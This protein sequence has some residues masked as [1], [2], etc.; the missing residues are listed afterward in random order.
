[1]S[2]H[3]G[4]RNGPPRPHLPHS[5]PVGSRPRPHAPRTGGWAW[6]SARPR[7]PHNEARDT[8]P[9]RAPLC[10]PHS[11]QRQHTRASTV[12]LITGHHAHCPCPHSQWVAGPGY[13]PQGQA[14]GRVRAPHP[15]R[16]TP[17]HEVPLS[18]GRPRAASTACKGSSQEH[19][20]S[21][22]WRLPRSGPPHPQ[23]V[24][25][26][27]RLHAPR[28]GSRARESAQTRTNH[29]KA[30]GAPPPGALVR[31]PQQAKQ[32]RK[33]AR[34]GVDDGS[35]RPQPRTHSKWVAGPGR[36]PVGWAVGPGKAYAPHQSKR[37][38][39]RG[40]LVLP[41][42]RAKAACKSARCGVGDASPCPHPPHSQPVGSGPRP[43]A[44]R[45]GDRAL[46]STQPRT[47]H[48]QAR[49]APPRRPLA[50]PTARK[51]SSQEQARP[52]GGK[53]PQDRQGDEG[54]RQTLPELNRRSR[55]PGQ[56]TWRGTNRLERPYQRPP[57]EPRVVHEPHRPGGGGRGAY[58]AGA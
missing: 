10:R 50:A 27:P 12:E 57:P 20:L 34:C 39:P 56:E 52:Q 40:T 51:G 54:T 47:P 26:G 37:R 6:V 31:P 11:A 8:T 24:G 35:P 17:R 38:P 32:A 2:A 13:T 21:G 49:G 7:T 55:G 45:T 23:P 41:A 14:V 43:H 9:S 5:Q 18:S 29:T 48:T 33:S 25:S 4:V 1:M 19:A 30:R 58:A 42:Q 28:T 22:R 53:R 46:E 36:M 44:P 3:C 16:P 15:G